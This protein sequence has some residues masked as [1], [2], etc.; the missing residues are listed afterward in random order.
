MRTE[1]EENEMPKEVCVC[2]FLIPQALPLHL[3]LE[4]VCVEVE[5]VYV[6]REPQNY[7]SHRPARKNKIAEISQRCGDGNTAP[8]LIH[9]PH[10]M[11]IQTNTKQISQ[12]TST[13]T[14]TML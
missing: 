8:R 1:G 11:M 2:V 9:K 6:V 13:E 4:G 14:G 7:T 10:R 12:L 5:G 3:Q